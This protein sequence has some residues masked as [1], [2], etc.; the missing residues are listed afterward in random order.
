MLNLLCTS[1][2]QTFTS[3][4]SLA[5]HKNVCIYYQYNIQYSSITGEYVSNDY[6]KQIV[7]LYMLLELYKL[8]SIKDKDNYDN[9]LI[10]FILNKT[11]NNI[12]YTNVYNTI[13]QINSEYISCNELISILS[14][15]LYIST[16]TF[17][18]IIDTYNICCSYFSI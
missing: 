10:S 12:M 6:I 17:C 16:N 13:S 18:N 8:D 7:K 1:C 15:I 2:G 3:V 4:K 5:F 9:I 14:K 11:K